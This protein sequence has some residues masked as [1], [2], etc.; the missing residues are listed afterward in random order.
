M[1]IEMK[2]IEE[3]FEKRKFFE[4]IFSRR[5]FVEIKKFKFFPF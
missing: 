3:T 5:I 1:M 4:G 2:C